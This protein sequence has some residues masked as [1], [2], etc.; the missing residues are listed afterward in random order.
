VSVLGGV[1]YVGAQKFNPA[2]PAKNYTK[3]ATR[4]EAQRQDIDYFRKLMALDRSYSG[5]SRQAA[6][7]LLDRL[8]GMHSALPRNQ[9]RAAL[10]RATAL[11]DNGHTSLYSAQHP[12]GR[13]RL[14]P[15]RVTQFADG[16]YVMRAPKEQG[17][18]L[19]A[20]LIAVA[21]TPVEA[22]LHK[23]EQYRG[24]TL[25]NRR[26]YAVVAL[27]ATD[28]L[29]GIGILPSPER[30]TW[31]LRTKA[32]EIVQRSF[33]AYQPAY[34]EGAPEL[35]RWL[36][37]EP[38]KRSEHGW[39][40]A[41]PDSP[42]IPLTFQEGD[43]LF[44][45]AWIGKSCILFLQLRAN[46]GDRIGAFLDASEVE[47]KARPPCAIIFDNRFN[48]GGDYTNT[49]GFAGR[50]LSRLRPGGHIYM[51]TGVETFSAGITTTVFVKQATAPAQFTLLGE[52]VGDRM[53]FWSE[54]G[55]GCLP[56]APFCFHYATGMH[57]YLHGGTEW[58]NCYWIN[59]IYP[60][61]TSSLTPDETIP[62]TFADWKAGRDP[63]FDR[64]LALAKAQTTVVTQTP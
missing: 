33:T 6:T 20:R 10:M 61:R 49:A 7:Q 53:I 25:A 31:T 5:A 47:M 55:S 8:D 34:D 38:A 64:A 17:D 9:L 16:I 18:I 62:M 48:G 42:Q 1:Y 27:T 30:A 46:Q 2:R 44:R 50:L 11:A 52:P 37:P 14:L 24:G 60:A 21:G 26:D 23:V 3:A 58:N 15:V 28:I 57:D 40:A 19:G 63:V 51:L 13:S 54:G 35:S 39:L 12:N 22:A 29:N 56:I 45:R 32:G 36:S 43:Q 59:R 41:R 4:L